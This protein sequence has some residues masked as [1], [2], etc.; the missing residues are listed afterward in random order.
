LHLPRSVTLL[1]HKPPGYLCTASD[2]HQRRTIFDLLPDNLPRLFHVGRLDK[3]SEGLLLVTND[4]D[5][6]LKLTHPRY[7]V[8]KEYEVVLNAP[9]DFSLAEKLKRGIMTPEGRAYAESVH[10]LGTNKVKLVLRQGL[11]RQIRHMF[12]ELGYEVQKLVRTR[13]GPLRIGKMPPGA[14]RELTGR[15]IEALLNAGQ[16]KLAT[17]RPASTAPKAA[18]GPKPARRSAAPP[19]P[20]R[21]KR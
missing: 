4:G 9:F 8:E 7:K 2:T 13:I 3:E 10:R 15:E 19:R 14:W 20:S 16:A 12:Y 1:L 11:K 6:A 18:S 17:P 5:L 21:K